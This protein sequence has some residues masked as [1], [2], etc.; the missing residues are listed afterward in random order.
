MILRHV[1]HLQPIGNINYKM[2]EKLLFDQNISY[3]VVDKLPTSFINCKQVNQIGLKDCN[4]MEIWQY[5]LNNNFTIVSFDS[6]FYDISLING[7]PPKVI[8]LRTG[9][10]TTIELIQRITLNL[11]VIETFL[12]NPELKDFACLEIE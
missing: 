9:N 8:W 2:P 3:R 1:W 7:C 5:A 11:D 12:N 4:D 10:I 6:D